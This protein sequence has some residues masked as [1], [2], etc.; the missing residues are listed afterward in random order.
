MAGAVSIGDMGEPSQAD[1]LWR[2]SPPPPMSPW[3]RGADGAPARPSPPPRLR[4]MKLDGGRV[5]GD[6]SR[7]MSLTEEVAAEPDWDAAVEALLA[8]WRKPGDG[9]EQMLAAVVGVGGEPKRLTKVLSRLGRRRS[10]SAAEAAERCVDWAAGVG[11]IALNVFHYS[12]LVATLGAQRR[13]TDAAARF[14]QMQVRGWL[15]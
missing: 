13:T 8:C 1:G 5:R 2:R 3:P 10:S 6:D 15:I 11:D 14:D 4:R 12:S 9:F 7:Q